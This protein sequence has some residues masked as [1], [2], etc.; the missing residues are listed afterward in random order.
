[1]ADILE[2]KRKTPAQKH[3]GK[4]LCRS[5]F[6]K[7]K[8]L[9]EKKFDVKQGRLVTVFQCSRCGKTKTTAL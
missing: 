2:F 3:K 4:S 1:M 8:I 7:W 5:G 9:T 6:H